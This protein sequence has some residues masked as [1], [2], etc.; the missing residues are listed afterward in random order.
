LKKNRESQGEYL[1]NFI[2]NYNKNN[3]SVIICGDFNDEPNSLVYNVFKNNDF[4][5]VYSFHNSS[6]E[7]PYTTVKKEKKRRLY[8]ALII[9]G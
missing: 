4:T 5:S 8:T 9:Y 6:G 2:K 7:E 3:H 1:T